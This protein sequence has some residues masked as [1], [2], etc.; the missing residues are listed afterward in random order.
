MET[1]WQDVR[2]AVR[3]LMRSPG[4]AAVAVLTMA[5]GIGA[6][7][8]IFS[9]VNTV[10]LQPMNYPHP[11]RLV[12]LEL[13]SPQGNGDTTSIPKFIVWREQTQVFDSVAAYDFSGPGIN[14]TGGDRP[15]QVKGIHASADYF[16]VFG[17]PLAIGRTY[18]RDEDRPGGPNVVVISNG[19]WHSRY[20]GDPGII[21]RSI[22]LGGAP[23]TVIGVLGGA[24]RTESP[25]DVWIPLRADPNST[26]QGHYLRATARLKPGVTLAQAQAAMRLAA[27]EFR[28]KFPNLPIMGPKDTFTA[29]AYR[30]SVIGDVR[31]G[32][33]LLF[34]AV[35][36]VLLIACANVANLL[37]ARATIRKR[38]IAIRA[39]LGAGRRRIILQLLTE[40]VLIS[41]AGGVLGLV[42]GY[43]G[44]RTLLAMNAGGIPRIG[45]TGSHVAL[46]GSVLAFTL[47]ISVLT[48]IVFGLIPAFGASRSDLSVTLR[49]SGSR[50]GT[51]LRH[52]KARSSLVVTE[53]ALALVLLAGAALLIRTFAAL[54]G[55]SPGFDVRDI[56]TME[57]SLNGERFDKAA[58]VDQLEREGR[59]RLESLPGVETAAMTCCLPLEGGFDL[60]FTIL[61]NPPKDSPYNGDSDYLLV[62]PRYFDVFRIPMLR[63]R[64]FSDEDSAAGSRVVIINEAMAK[65]YWPKG[66]ALG[67]QI[68]IGKGVGP[69]F[70]EPPR[71]IIGIAG[72]VHQSGLG[73]PADEIM[74]IPIAQVNDGIIALNNRIT[75]MTWAVRTKVP[76]FSLSSEI[77]TQLR[78]A[79]GGLPV[80]HIRSMAQVEGESLDQNNFN[81]TL[82]T[83]FAGIALV[84][85]AI[86]VYGLMAYSVQQRTQEIGIRM[87]LGASPQKVRSMVVSQG[88]RLAAVGVIFGVAAALAL[89]R[90]M[91]SLLYGVKP[92]DPATIIGMAAILSGVTWLATYVPARRASRV[93]PMVALRYE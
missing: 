48:G 64:S 68:T 37:L 90:L 8:A 23:F 17:A 67:A 6:N 19:L 51:S 54:E 80:A 76:P 32:L 84:L 91:S 12:E 59:Q 78:E 21:G 85:A 34:G 62:S 71:E 46:D 1:L 10:L 89:T 27:D 79:S 81:M 49:E 83:I 35:G 82:L 14:L 25:I 87:A 45:E 9:V 41:L 15:E 69:E 11:E 3:L 44:V 92:W 75:P 73:Q 16:R 36:F 93:D 4:F 55:V 65:K 40:S 58:G 66:D 5:L 70:E 43:A 74:Y 30:D 38:E 56:L 7:T 88:M 63:G 47:V 39:A 2:Y 61:G 60:P 77:Q 24:F 72:N 13:S 86:G 57:M 29:V 26:D 33:L 28:R 18:T 53:I 31:K 22:E 50:A 20:G 42:L 52:N